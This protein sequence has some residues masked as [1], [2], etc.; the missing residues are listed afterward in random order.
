MNVCQFQVLRINGDLW[1]LL[2]TKVSCQNA[3][4]WGLIAAMLQ[5][6]TLNAKPTPVGVAFVHYLL[7]YHIYMDVTCPIVD[8]NEPEFPPSFLFCI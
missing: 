8:S 6:H 7:Y 4:G 5:P 3:L 1:F 2:D